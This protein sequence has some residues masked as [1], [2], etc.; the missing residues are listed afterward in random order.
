MYLTGRQMLWAG[1]AVAAVLAGGAGPARAQQGDE[2]PLTLTG[3][4]ELPFSDA[5]LQ[6]ALLARLLSAPS[7]PGPPRTQVEPVGPGVVSVRVGDRT[8]TVTVGDRTGTAAAR[9]VALVIADL[10]SA[11]EATPP[12]A[13]SLRQPV[14]AVTV[15]TPPTPELQPVVPEARRRWRLV[16]AGGA[17]KGTSATELVAGTLN[18]DLVIAPR[19]GGFKL[20]PSLGLTAM[21]TRNPGALNEVS[22]LGL[23][24][25]MLA[26]FSQGPVDVLAGPIGSVYAIGGATAHRGFL[27]G[28]E[29]MARV[30]APLSRRMRLAVDARADLWGNRVRVHWAD[31]AGGSSAT[32]RVGLGVDVGLAWDWPS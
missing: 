16:V 14:E 24:A 2:A 3:S 10:L 30:A 5:E 18:G 19:N 20:A 21:P 9:V 31:G 7:E 32:P 23:T 27:F 4:R 15:A 17:S 26:G 8:R 28:G 12:V 1:L 13:P 11:P 22:F 6:Q 25:R 29:L